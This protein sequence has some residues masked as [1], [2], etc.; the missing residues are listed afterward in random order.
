MKNILLTGACGYV[1]KALTSELQDLQIYAIDRS[2]ASSV[3][4]SSKQLFQNDLNK[5]SLEAID[6]LYKFSG[7]VVHLAAARSDDSSKETYLADNIKA[8]E[9]LLTH[10]DPKKIFRFVHIGS[11]AAIDGEALEEQNI[12]PLSADDWY[13]STKFRQQQLIEA[14]SVR[15]NIPLIILAPSAIY[16]ADAKSNSTNI[17][18]L[19]KIVTFLR[20]VPEINIL[21]S[22]TSMKSLVHAIKYFINCEL[23]KSLN[24]GSPLIRK[25]LVLDTPTITITE[26][27]KQKFNAKI[28]IKIPYFK[29]LLLIL[30]SFIKLI[31]LQKKIPL[32]T[33]R[34][35]KLYKSTDYTNSPNYLE[36]DH[37][38]T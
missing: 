18:R 17:G 14:W 1:G 25:Y 7:I 26:I 28:T 8:T 29:K 33:E 24:S 34:V 6:F 19:E 2:I 5:L 37:E 31:G 35:Q 23:E 4:R 15:N 30:A 32:S 38:E 10:L 27:C 11:V 9:A 16:D 22:L 12:R 13:R 3:V 20:I 21:K 36:W